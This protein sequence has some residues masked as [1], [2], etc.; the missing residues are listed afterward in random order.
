MLG[1]V[2]FL[3]GSIKEVKHL[4]SGASRLTRVRDLKD[5]IKNGMH[6]DLWSFQAQNAQ[7]GP[8]P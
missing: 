8:F 1:L 5:S 6:L 4:D 2:L 7:T 3:K